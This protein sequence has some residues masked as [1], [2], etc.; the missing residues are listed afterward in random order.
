MGRKSKNK[1]LQ[2]QK[3]APSL[4]PEYARGLNEGFQKGVEYREAAH[5]A[6]RVAENELRELNARATYICGLVVAGR[7]DTLREMLLPA[8]T[9]LGAQIA[10]VITTYAKARATKLFVQIKDPDLSQANTLF[11]QLRAFLQD[12]DDDGETLRMLFNVWN[13]VFGDQIEIRKTFAPGRRNTETRKTL[14]QEAA[15]LLDAGVN[16][17]TAVSKLSEN[18]AYAKIISGWSDSSEVLRKSV[19]RF[20]TKMTKKAGHIVLTEQNG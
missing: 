6:H 14:D 10:M 16:M 4:T 2:I 18:P 8:A 20:N 5:R 12:P 17:P 19:E 11:M 3:A 1:S 15:A 9:D 7:G 13:P